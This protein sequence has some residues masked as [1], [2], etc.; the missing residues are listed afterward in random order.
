MSR[1]DDLP[2]D[3][4]AALALLLR[5]RKSYHEVAAILGIEPAA[6]HDRAHAALAILSPSLARRLSPQQREQIG[7][8]LLGQQQRDV[9]EATRAQLA[10]SAP[11]REWARAL[12][13]ELVSLAAEP[14]PEI[15]SPAIAAA[16][17]PGAAAPVGARAQS[18][19]GTGES[20]GSGASAQGRPRIE[21][22]LPSSRRGGALL[23]AGIA[24]AAIVA[25]AL[26][27]GGKGSAGPAHQAASTK[28]KSGGSAG[29]TASRTQGT[30]SKSGARKDA[31]SHSGGKSSSE[32]SKGESTGAG[33]GGESATSGS[34]GASTTSGSSSESTG[35]GEEPKLEH[36][37]NLTATELGGS[38]V[39]ILVTAS[40][41]KQHAIIL[42]AEHLEPS[43]SF[44]YVLWLTGTEGSVQPHPVLIEVDS[45]GR[46]QGAA[47][48]P[49]NA[50]SYNHVEITKETESTPASPSSEVVL[51]GEFKA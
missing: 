25:I 30:G 19:A 26:S 15:P 3:Q 39:G 48:L 27:V 13:V 51:E 50:S 18:A 22:R 28:T 20:A 43:E 10:L 38:A 7:E 34:G 44:K 36:Q 49:A 12:T 11:A 40:L 41:G 37:F 33:A 2:P 47:K 16:I 31:A 45:K 17:A 8:Y 23:L 42:S 46:V 4:R 35:S 5:R 24:I 32:G 21:P 9:A 1:I 6:L 29:Q 14:L